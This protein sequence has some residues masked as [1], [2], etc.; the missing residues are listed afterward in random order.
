MSN[1]YLSSPFE[2]ASSSRPLARK[3]TFNDFDPSSPRAQGCSTAASSSPYLYQPSN[4]SSTPQHSAFLSSPPTVYSSPMARSVSAQSTFNSFM[5]SLGSSPQKASQFS[6][7]NARPGMK[8]RKTIPSEMGSPASPIKPMQS[9]QT[10]LEGVMRGNGKDGEDVWPPHVEEAFQTAIRLLPRLGRKK[11]IINGKACGRNELIGDYIKRTTGVER[12][13]KQVSSHIQVLKNMRKDDKEFMAIL[14]DPLEGD[15]RF[16]P[17][18]ARLFFGSDSNMGS[19]FMATFLEHSLASRDQTFPPPIDLS[20][21]LQLPPL[22]RGGGLLPSP[23]GTSPAGL[24]SPFAMQSQAT[25]PTSTLANA[26]RDMTVLPPPTPSAIAASV[27]FAPVEFVMRV[28]PDEGSGRRAPHVYTALDARMGPTGKVFLEDLPAG[29]Q[30]YPMLGDMVDHL[31][32]Q[33]LH[34][35]FDLDVPTTASAVGL[36]ST[37]EAFMRLETVQGLP[38]TAVT[39]VFCH[40]EEIINFS[41]Q[42]SPSILI[43]TPQRRSSTGRTT[44]PS[45]P[46]QASRHKYSY[47]VPFYAEYW[48]PLFARNGLASTSNSRSSGQAVDFGRVGSDRIDFAQSISAFSVLQE[49]VVARE[50]AAP[51]V[52]GQSLCRGSALGDVILV[53]AYDFAVCEGTMKAGA[54]LSFLS[55]RNSPA[56]AMQLP[57]PP[58]SAFTPRFPPQAAPPMSRSFTSPLSIAIAPPPLAQQSMP[59]PPLP[60]SARSKFSPVKPNLSLHIPPPSQYVR[61]SSTGSTPSSQP[62]PSPGLRLNGPLTP[63]GQVVH[64]P[65]APPP[66][67][68]APSSA[69]QLDRDRLEHIW[70]QQAHSWDLHSPA[71]MGVSAPPEVYPTLQASP[72]PTPPPQHFK[73]EEPPLYSTSFLETSF[74]TGSAFDEAVAFSPLPDSTSSSSF[75]DLSATSSSHS[76]FNDIS[77]PP[78]DFQPNGPPRDFYQLHDPVSPALVPDLVSSTGSTASSSSF[79]SSVIAMPRYTVGPAGKAKEES[80]QEK[81]KMEQ[82]FFSSVF[83]SS[84]KYTGVY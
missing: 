28:A 70:R 9:P 1:P 5:Q 22:P 80:P 2:M 81:R 19:P 60:A 8:R 54:E 82:D 36:G 46:G 10:P 63:W 62:A 13:R 58:R 77:P 31:P 72:L 39:T 27:P 37:L 25:T 16:A 40:G 17:G 83:G 66:V 56:Q 68:V 20:A 55:K 23:A 42:L 43:D 59:P 29:L 35:R 12:S 18:N 33:F 52:P 45:P 49:F 38:L 73:V 34:A 7:D 15:D 26:L 65:N 69:N 53:V 30:R 71:L 75:V 64:T 6:P 21:A 3:R 24:H 50:D 14:A 74:D 32:C 76:S 51:F 11:L 78:F 79:Q 44:P 67:Q 41:E 4:P 48:L 84:T 57:V 47:H 61:R